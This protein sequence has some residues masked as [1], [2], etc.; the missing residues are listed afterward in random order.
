MPRK[1]IITAAVAASLATSANASI[2]T[3]AEKLDDGDII[4]T[5]TVADDILIHEISDTE[6]GDLIGP[7]EPPMDLTNAADDDAQLL[8]QTY[9][10]GSAAD[11]IYAGGDSVRGNTL[12]GIKKP[13][14]GITLDNGIKKPG[15]GI[16]LDNGIKKPAKLRKGQKLPKLRQ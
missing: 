8:A 6:L 14:Q 7:W 10:G 9:Y 15:K 5:G 4:A 3:T 11:T 12:P 13:G 1:P 2:E 16:T